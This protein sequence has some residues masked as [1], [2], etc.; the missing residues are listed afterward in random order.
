MEIILNPE[1]NYGWTFQRR[2]SSDAYY[3][4]PISK[5]NNMGFKL[6]L[7]KMHLANYLAHSHKC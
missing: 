7:V 6:F 4:L 3:F 1:W 5:M 2:R